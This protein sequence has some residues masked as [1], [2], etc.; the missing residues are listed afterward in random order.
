MPIAAAKPETIP[1]IETVLTL[2]ASRD[3]IRELWPRME[4]VDDLASPGP[5]RLVNV[6]LSNGHKASVVFHERKQLVEILAPLEVGI[7]AGL[8]RLLIELS[9]APDAITWAH[10]RINR[11]ALLESK[12]R[13]LKEREQ[14]YPERLA[15]L[16]P[17]RPVTE[18]TARERK[19]ATE[20]EAVQSFQGSRSDGMQRKIRSD[21]KVGT[22]EKKLGL[23]SG[24]IRNPD[25]SDARS[26][27][28]LGTLRKEQRKKK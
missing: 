3:D 1:R 13:Y 20:V 6:E 27:K 11:Q 4:P 28:R 21:I 14:D 19:S 15:S 25:G 7:E 2:R 17:R 8:A 26:D 18:A 24:A 22:L 9:I 5:A 16:S 10:G 23:K 12:V